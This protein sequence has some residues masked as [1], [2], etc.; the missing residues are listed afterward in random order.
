MQNEPV[1]FSTQRTSPRV[2]SSEATHN[3]PSPGVRGAILVSAVGS[4]IWSPVVAGR[5]NVRHGQ[6]P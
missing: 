3:R 2:C 4:Q 5:S 1:Q 6:A